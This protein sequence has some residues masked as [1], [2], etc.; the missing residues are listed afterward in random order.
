VERDYFT[1]HL[2]ENGYVLGQRRARRY[3]CKDIK[4]EVVQNGF[5]AQGRLVDFSALAF[6]VEVSPEEVGSFRWLMLANHQPSIF[7]GMN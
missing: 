4:V 1:I 7:T 5:Y 2:P 6:S 3:L